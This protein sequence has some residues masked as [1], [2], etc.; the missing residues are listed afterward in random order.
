M[1]TI[2]RDETL[3]VVS[4]KAD[5]ANLG[6]VGATWKARGDKKE[7]RCPTSLGNGQFCMSTLARHDGAW[8]CND[9]GEIRN[10]VRKTVRRKGDIINRQFIPKINPEKRTKNWTGVDGGQCFNAA[11]KADADEIKRRTG[12]VGVLKMSGDPGD[13]QGVPIT[14][15]VFDLE[16]IT[17]K[18]TEYDIVD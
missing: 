16:T 8:Y 12:L 3:A 6:I 13:K 9:H 17:F 1:P 14:I 2:T 15:P 18:G 4:G 11:T 7:T 5:F 10:P